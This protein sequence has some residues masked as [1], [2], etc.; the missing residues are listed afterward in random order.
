VIDSA[1]MLNTI[2]SFFKDNISPDTTAD[3]E[4]QLKLATAALLIEMMQQDHKVRDEERQVVR[5]ALQEKF[6]LADEETDELYELAQAEADEA[7]DYFQFTSL[8]A[9]ECSQEQKI[10]IIEYLWTIAYADSHLDPLEEHM[11][12][13]IA[14]LIYVPHKDFIRAKQKVVNS[15]W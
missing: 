15:D 11:I 13:R 14:D 2:K 8:I 12:R 3:L 1:N 9:R 6:D 7:V 5:Q 10:K 4:H